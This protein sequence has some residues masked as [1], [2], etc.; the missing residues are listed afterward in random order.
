LEKIS[1]ETTSNQSWEMAN[2]THKIVI[3][4][5]AIIP[6]SCVFLHNNDKG[7]ALPKE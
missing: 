4:R 2:N 3:V 1:A 7:F 6:I 5:Q